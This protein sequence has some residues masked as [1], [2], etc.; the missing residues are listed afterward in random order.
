METRRDDS[1]EAI[2]EGAAQL[3]TVHCTFLADPCQD[4]DASDYKRLVP[5]APGSR[6]SARLRRLNR[7]RR[8]DGAETIV[9]YDAANFDGAGP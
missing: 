3:V 7:H 5:A 8:A 6:R 1:G 4:A 9:F 2:F